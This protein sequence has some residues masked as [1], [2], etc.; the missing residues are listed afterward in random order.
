MCAHGRAHLPGGGNPLRWDDAAGALTFGKR[1]GS[2]KDMPEKHKLNMVIVKAGHG[3][4]GEVAAVLDKTVSYLGE[5]I[6]VK[7]QTGHSFTI[8][9]LL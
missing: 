8:S 4:G 9:Q 5:K 2:F 1:E 7:F 3:M 6:T